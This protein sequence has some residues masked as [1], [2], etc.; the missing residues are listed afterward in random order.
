MNR[1]F[2]AALRHC[3]SLFSEKI[4]NK[5]NFAVKIPKFKVPDGQ[6]GERE[7]YWFETVDF[8]KAGSMKFHSPAG[9]SY[10]SLVRNARGELRSVS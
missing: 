10:E 2:N 8:E 6:R 9:V 1:S 3:K 7:V 4:I 5:P